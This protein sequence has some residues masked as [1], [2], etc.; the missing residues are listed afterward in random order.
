MEKYICDVRIYSTMT[1]F[2]LKYLLKSYG[3]LNPLIME[4]N[5]EEKVFRGIITKEDLLNFKSSIDEIIAK[6]T[7]ATV[8]DIEDIEIFSFPMDK[9]DLIISEDSYM[10][11]LII[12]SLKHFYSI[13]SVLEERFSLSQPNSFVWLQILRDAPT[14]IMPAIIAWE[15]YGFGSSTDLIEDKELLRDHYTEWIGSVWSM[16]TRHYSSIISGQ[17]PLKEFDLGHVLEGNIRIII[18]NL[19]Y[20][21]EQMIENR[22]PSEPFDLGGFDF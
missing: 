16:L 8:C 15:Y 2:E 9:K 7:N 17:F 3:L 10:K 18:E 19:L 1:S 11:I 20:E 4:I 14:L 13:S 12:N 6:F 21:G 22:F 5:R